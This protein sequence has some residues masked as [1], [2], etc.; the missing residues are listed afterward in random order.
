M[1]AVREITEWKSDVQPNHVYLLDGSKMVAYMPWG[2]GAPFYFKK[3]MGFDRKGRKFE[4]LKKNPFKQVVED[5]RRKVEGSKG[6][7]Y[8]VDDEAQTCTC[9]GFSFRSTCKHLSK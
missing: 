7:V 4:K 2:K 1:E 8:W 6:A 9:M 3:P 5:T